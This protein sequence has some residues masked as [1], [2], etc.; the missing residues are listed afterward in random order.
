MKTVL[1][2]AVCSVTF[3]SIFL[4]CGCA[5]SSGVADEAQ[6]SGTSKVQAEM[7]PSVSISGDAIPDTQVQAPNCLAQ[8]TWFGSS[9]S[10]QCQGPLT[11]GYTC[12][13]DS[14]NYPE[15]PST[16]GSCVQALASWVDSRGCQQAVFCCQL[17]VNGGAY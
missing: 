13:S 11:Q 7:Q 12:Q 3:A 14:A 6:G 17:S 9:S 10:F 4:F 8:C 2:A 5:V 15:P 1:F 16:V